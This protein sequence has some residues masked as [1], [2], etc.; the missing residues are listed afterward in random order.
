M[1]QKN[2]IEHTIRVKIGLIFLVIILYFCGVFIYSYGLKKNIDTQK[3]EV[4]HSY[5]ILSHTNQLIS[6]LQQA[7][8]R[9]NAYLASPRK[10][11]RRQYDSISTDIFRQIE[12]MKAI[13]PQKNQEKLLENIHVLL[14]DRNLI[15]HKLIRQ[16]R[17][18]NPLEELDQKLDDYNKI[19]E[20]TIIS[21]ADKDSTVVLHEKKNFWTRLKGLFSPQHATDTTIYITRTEKDIRLKSGVDT[22]IYSDLKSITQEASKTYS[23]KILGIEKQVGHLVLSEQKISLR[24]SQL[25]TKLHHEAIET[26][27]TGVQ[28]GEELTQRIFVFSVAVGVLSLMLILVIIF[29]I[30][31]DLRKGQQ[32]RMELATE[33]QRTENLMESRHK[34]L[35]SVSHDIKTPL[36]SIMGYIDLWNLNE[37]SE[38]RKQQIR[39]ARNSGQHILSMLSNLLEFSRLEQNSGKLHITGFDL[40]ELAEET[41][42]MFRPFT[43][44]KGI[45]MKFDNRTETP[46]FVET[47][48]TILKQILTNV[49]SNAVKYTLRGSIH[50]ALEAEDGKVI[51]RVTD[52]GVGIDNN[53][54]NDIFKPFSRIKSSLKVEGSGFGMYVTKGLVDSLKGDIRVQSEKHKG[55]CVNIELP[56]R[57]VRNIDQGENKKLSPANNGQILRNILIFEDHVALGNMMKEYLLQKGY[58]VT[59][60]NTNERIKESLKEISSFD[61]VF[62]DMDMINITGNEILR[63]IRKRN[64]DIPVW[65]MT[66]YDDLSETKALSD[67]FD[68]FIKKPINMDNLSAILSAEEET[69]A[70]KPQERSVNEAFPLLTSLFENDEKTIGDILSKF[71]QTTHTDTEKLEQMIGGNDFNGAQQLCH[72]IHPFLAQLNAEHLCGVLRKMDK[73][74]GQDQSAYPEWKEELIDAV[75]KLRAFAEEIN[76]NYLNISR[77]DSCR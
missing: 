2:P 48:Y 14:D 30:I 74:R 7:Q 32:A 27:R 65:L 16:L 17:V 46:F 6:S 64:T 76:K 59:L 10:I 70:G 57:Q 4:V 21:S 77:E 53:D 38:S 35:L 28:K 20:D 12:E 49:L 75:S 8:S 26:S 5:Q 19:A 44:E 69:D 24:I 55:T 18:Q 51:F 50:L 23:T 34:L 9:T 22:A 56:L 73:L 41:I 58:K 72:K 40:I 60:C 29:F 61:I 37:T 33:K 15:V 36:T 3:E 11:Y 39:S 1:K 68:G 66:A 45:G 52:T 71:V 31:N 67:G 54:I 25:L 13:S 43:A 42:N 62:T 47:D 63:A